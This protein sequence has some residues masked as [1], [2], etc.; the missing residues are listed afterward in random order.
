M[1]RVT[2]W[3]LIVTF[4]LSLVLVAIGIYGVTL[5]DAETTRLKTATLSDATILARGEYLVRAGNCIGCH[6]VRGGAALAG[7]RV[8]Q[9][10]FGEFIT[11]NITPD[12]KTGIGSWT[13]DDFWQALHNGK[14]KSGRL[15][16]P[17]FPFVNYTQVSR[18][19]ADAM[20]AFLQGRG[21]V[22]Q[23]NQPHRLHFPYDQRILLSL[24]RAF[25]F[26]P[27]VFSPDTRQTIVWNR[28]AYLVRGLGHCSACHSSRNV[29]GAN[30]G[31]QDLSG[32]EMPLVHWYAPSLESK[33]EASLLSWSVSDAQALLSTGIASKAITSGLMSEVVANSL[34]YL[35]DTDIQSI[36]VYL[37]ALP[38]DKPIPKDVLDSLLQTSPGVNRDEMAGWVRQGSNLY[39]T[40]CASCHANGGEGVPFIYPALKGNQALLMAH[41]GNPIRITLSGGFAPATLKKPRPYSMP[42]FAP[43]LSDTEV[44]LILTYVRNAWGNHATP[45]TA[46]DVN[47]YRTAPLD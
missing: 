17:A 16:Y 14:G 40:H 10:E 26:K 34:Q 12:M 36:Q 39:M 3:A 28:G 20:Y 19:D 32:G 42:P 7:G 45:V 21:S 15:L 38:Q 47:Q 23:E 8:L 25:F 29:F 22:V 6:T 43:T 18:E 1:K 27:A 13:A 4:V 30:Q 46:A 31:N 2:I 41:V 5:G 35:S 33:K 44:A 9:S 24:W 11:P 37:Q